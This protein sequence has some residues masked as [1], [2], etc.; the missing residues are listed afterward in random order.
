VLQLSR[1]RLNRASVHSLRSQTSPRAAGGDRSSQLA[2]LFASPLDEQEGNGSN[3]NRQ[4]KSDEGEQGLRFDHDDLRFVNDMASALLLL[5][6]SLHR[7]LSD[8]IDVGITT[9]EA[10]CA[11]RRSS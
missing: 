5:T 7:H 4:R 1:V 9:V 6:N 10:L 3:E 11:L 2:S 8:A